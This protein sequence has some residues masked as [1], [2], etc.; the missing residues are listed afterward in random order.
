[1]AEA[2]PLELAGPTFTGIWLAD[3]LDRALNPQI[4]ELQN[5]DGDLVV[6]CTSTFLLE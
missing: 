6:M 4:P 2:M 3:A 5:T 1:L